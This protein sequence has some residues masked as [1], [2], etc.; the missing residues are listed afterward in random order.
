M[1]KLNCFSDNSAQ[2]VAV[3][4]YV[5]CSPVENSPEEEVEEAGAAEEEK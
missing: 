3:K 1:F 5:R 4:R 2:R